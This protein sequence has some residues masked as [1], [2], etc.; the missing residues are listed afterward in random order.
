MV[1]LPAMLVEHGD[2]GAALNRSTE[3]TRNRRGRVLGTF[4]IGAL[5]AGVPLGLLDLLVSRLL[6][7]DED[8]SGYDIV[9]WL[10]GAAL[11]TVL[12]SLPA[13]LY[14]LLRGEQDGKTPDEIAAGLDQG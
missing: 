9:S 10:T 8:S 12:A 6:G 11:A 13:V 3:L 5:I 14:V 2:I 1:A 7:F 4:I